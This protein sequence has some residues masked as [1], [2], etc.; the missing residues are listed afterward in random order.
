VAIG[1]GGAATVVLLFERALPI[2]ADQAG[3]YA[4][5]ISISF[6]AGVFGRNIIELARQK[7]VDQ[8]VREALERKDERKLEARKLTEEA[9]NAVNEKMFP[10]ALKLLDAALQRDPDLIYAYIEKGRALKRMG[11]L[12]AALATLK[13]ALEKKP[14]DAKVL[15]N[16]ACYKTL[17]DFPKPEILA[18]LTNALYGNASLRIEA[19]TDDDFKALCLEPEFRR[20]VGLPEAQTQTPI[21]REIAKD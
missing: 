21:D 18:N 7:L 14:G 16:M 20:L 6:I 10:E 12:E 3:S 15:Y 4:L 17:L 8:R 9:R 2:Q 19:K 13:Q 5:L 11:K 1:I